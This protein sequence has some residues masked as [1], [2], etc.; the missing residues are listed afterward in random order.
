MP[1]NETIISNNGSNVSWDPKN[2]TITKRMSV[3][4]NGAWGGERVDMTVEI[5][6]KGVKLEQI[7]AWAAQ[8]LVINLQQ[9]LRKCD[10]AFVKDLAKSVYKRKATAMGVLDDPQRLFNK[11]LD[12]IK[13]GNLT[14]DQVS[15]MLQELQSMIPATKKN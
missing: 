8:T 5:D 2:E 14:P 10:L 6:F 7:Y 1:K 12:T 4:N 9:G 11:T 13:N 15:R 3:T